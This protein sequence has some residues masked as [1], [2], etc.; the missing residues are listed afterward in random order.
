MLEKLSYRLF[1][2]FI[3]FVQILPK[4]SRRIFFFLLARVI[5]FFAF[6][7]NKTIKTNLNFVFNNKLSKM[8]IRE[9]QKYSYFNTTLWVL[10]LIENLTI[11]DEDLEESVVVENR[12]II[13]SL[14]KEGKSIIL[15]SA[16]F[17]N[18]E[19][20]STYMNKFV[21]AIVQV[22]RESNFK[23][24]DKFIVKAR[25]NA[26][27]KI[28]FRNGAVR[29]LVKALIQKEVIS[30]IIDQNINSKEGT[31]VDFLGKKANQ[32]STSAILSRKFN[33]YI[34]PLGIFNQKNYK[35]KIKIYE[36]I[37]PIKTNNKENDIKELSQLQANA[38]S[39]IINEDKKQW[40][41]AHK[42]FK[43]HHKGIYEKNFNNK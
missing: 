17:G 15:I 38:I 30:L 3:K 8:E 27:G 14:K 18:M 35:Y 40:F 22:A 9:I 24:F 21:T 13:D 37:K 42:R 4:V 6:K 5:Y 7:T 16:H 23:A 26:G 34:V 1:L 33:A 25:E 28:I 10:S 43:S 11:S 32:T 41:W 12:E 20:M 31:E 2:I 39:D 29:K 36:S 19:M